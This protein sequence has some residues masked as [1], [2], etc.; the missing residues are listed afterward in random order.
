MLRLPV[1]VCLLCLSPVAFAD[2]QPE[3]IKAVWGSIKFEGL[4][5]V[6]QVDSEPPQRKVTMPRLNNR[7]KTLVADGSDVKLKFVPEPEEWV[8][9]LPKTLALPATLRLTLIEP[10]RLCKQPFEIQPTKEGIVELPAHHAITHGEKLRFEPQPH[11]NTIGYWTIEKDWAE[12]NFE[13]PQDGDFQCEVLQGCGKGQGGSTVELRC[14]R[15]SDESVVSISFEVQD[16]GHFQNFVPR[17]AGTFKLT[18]GGY[19]LEVR[20]KTKANKAVCDIRQI[21]LVPKN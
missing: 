14:V 13:L 19:R 8:I 7:M 3:S 6:I 17:S 9:T 12:W 21:R 15:V 10:A 20:P 18:K 4:E 5:V 1:F 11:K 2:C 16:T